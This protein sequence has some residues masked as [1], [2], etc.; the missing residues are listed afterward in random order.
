VVG[1]FLKGKMVSA[2]PAPGSL[3]GHPFPTSSLQL[4]VCRPERA[5]WPVRAGKAVKMSTNQ[6][7]REKRW[8]LEGHYPVTKHTPFMEC[9]Y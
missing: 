8:A 4:E 9:W 7:S 6:S 3:S 5:A 2:A 1:S